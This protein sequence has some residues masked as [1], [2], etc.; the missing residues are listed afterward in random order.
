[1]RLV[2]PS[3]PTRQNPACDC[4][5]DA[6]WGERTA[7][8]SRSE[9]VERSARVRDGW[10]AKT[11]LERRVTGHPVAFSLL[12]CA[13]PAEAQHLVDDTREYFQPETATKYVPRKWRQSA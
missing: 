3:L 10:T 8:P 12:R 11:E 9:I 6:G 5:K 1:M 7:N 2:T 4:D 13:V